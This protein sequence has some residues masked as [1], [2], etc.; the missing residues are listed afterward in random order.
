MAT[1]TVKEETKQ[2][3]KQNRERKELKLKVVRSISLV[4]LP[5][6]RPKKKEELMIYSI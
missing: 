5:H 1:T 6:R 3:G 4:C 2:R